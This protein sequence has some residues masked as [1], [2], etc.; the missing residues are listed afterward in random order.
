MPS[1][2]PMD[3]VGSAERSYIVIVAAQHLRH[4]DPTALRPCVVLQI[5]VDESDRHAALPDRGRN[6]F[7]QAQPHVPTR[8][9]T[10]N[11]RFK[12][13][14]VAAMRPVPG[15]HHIVTGQNIS[16]GIACDVRWQ[17]PGLR[18]GSNE[19]VKAAAVMSAHFLAYATKNVDRR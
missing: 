16:V 13:V 12:K 9:N 8:E 4:L 1:T 7:Y 17:P 18:V 14:G 6:T 2:N 3:K 19:D 15:L 11:T 10:G 5:L